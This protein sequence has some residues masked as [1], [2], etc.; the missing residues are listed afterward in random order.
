MLIIKKTFRWLIYA[1]LVV[2]SLMLIVAAVIRFVIFPNIDH[3]KDDISK[4]ISN[5]IGLKTTIGNIQTGWDGLSPEIR[6]SELDI[7]DDTQS[8]LH[9]NNIK[10]TFSWLS[11]PTLH[12]HLSYISIDQPK[13]TIHRK[14]NG[15]IY[16][17]GIAMTGSGEPDFANWILSQAHIR[18]KNAVITWQDDVKQTPPFS[19][20]QVTLNLENPAW[21]KI[22]GQHLFTLS[23]KPS[24]GT[25]YPIHLDGSFFGRNVS[26]LDSWRGTI[27]L[28]SKALDLTAWEPWLN[29]PVD[30]QS[31]LGD[32]IITFLFSNNKIDKIKAD[33][34]LQN[35]TGRIKQDAPLFNVNLLSGILTWEAL[36]DT[37][38]VTAQNIKL[39]TQN[40]HSIEDGSG[41]VSFSKRN[42]KPWL[43]TSL[44]FSTFNLNF[45]KQIEQYIDIPLN[46]SEPLNALSP[47]GELTNLALSFQGN[48]EKPTHFHIKSDFNNLGIDAYEKI[49]G[50][51]NLKG[52]IDA[53]EDKGSIELNTQDATLNLKDILRWPIPAKD[54][55]GKISWSNKGRLK[56]I[57][58]DLI[59]ASDHIR[60]K[61]TASYDMNGIK[62]GYLDIKGEFDDG[63]AKYAPF[64]Y[65][66]IMGKET[67]DWLDSAIVSGKANDVLLTV[68]GYVND[69][70][71]ID[72]QNKPDPNL[73]QFKVSARITDAVL[74]YGKS[75]PKIEGLALNMLFEGNSMELNADK[76]K[77]Y[78]INILK[79]KAVIPMLNTYGANSQELRIDGV[80][81]GPVAE[82]IK[83]INNSPV[84]DVTLGFTDDLKTAGTGKLNLKLNLPLNHIVDSTFEGDYLI[85]NGTIYANERLDF[86][87]ISN[88][89]GLLNFDST[90]IHSKNIK[91]EVLGGPLQFELLTD[92]DKTINIR[93]NGSISDKGI[94]Q[95]AQNLFTQSLEGAANW[96]ADIAIKKPIVN[97]SLRSDLK[98]LSI[99]L[100]APIGKSS[101]QIATL[102]IIK[103]QSLA[104]QDNVEIT[105]KDIIS[106]LILRN[107]KNGELAFDRGDIAFN[108]PPKLPS[109]PSLSIHGRFDY[110]NA[111]EWIALNKGATAK[112]TTSL[113]V[114]TTDI[115]IDKLDIFNRSLNGLNITSTPDSGPLKITLKSQEIDGFIEWL[116]PEK[117]NTNGKVIAHLK[118]LHIPSSNDES[119]KTEDKDIRKLDNKYPALDIQADDFKLGIKEFGLLELKAFQID[120]DWV[121]EQLKMTNADYVFQSEGR[122][123][124]WARNPNTNLE[125]SLAA[126]NVGKTFERLGQPNVIKGGVALISGRL[127]WPGSPHQFKKTGLTGQFTLGASKGEILKVQPGVGRLFGL[128][129]LQSLPRRLTLDFRDLFSEGFA[130]DVISATAKVD[131]GVMQSNDFFMTGP[132][133]ETKIKGQI[134]LNEETQN[135]KVKVVPHIS[136]T[137]SLAALAGGPIAGAAAF[138]AQKLLKDPLNKIAQTE[139]TITGTWANPIDSEAKPEKNKEAPTISPL[140]AQQN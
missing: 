5:K 52:K 83:F 107:E 121:I 61:L 125:F 28:N 4:Q 72:K 91:G 42:K 131:N 38:T 84:K 55:N 80:S 31:G 90:G 14:E 35:L 119:N 73:G 2:L 82:G 120:D 15:D 43:S 101:D 20:S 111:D 6:I 13:L 70:P 135:L 26:K 33:I 97:L 63:N 32:S 93:A 94:Q 126:N 53:D 96:S 133:A 110:L 17:A 81:E 100:P 95:Y 113:K 8:A 12:P 45:L 104:A 128:L 89:N 47:Q 105:Y 77:I 25:Q 16:I 30:L 48:P 57:A 134:D 130:F 44:N 123:Q 23:A 46:L 132:A 18:I 9:L 69:F 27:N 21:R 59:I 29:Y 137:L 37:T 34:T 1:I 22:F 62:G 108:I 88:I 122:W 65:P 71:F 76:G 117:T 109:T 3:Y 115:V 39:N 75:W 36:K 138:I 64:Y 66:T 98:G 124:N 87:E 102:M 127:Q 50:F 92:S 112:N 86:P 11:I 129:T 78:G 116:K 118:K 106:A 139:Y 49:P 60:G 7:Y 79:G 10:G 58:N 99:N 40:E 114:D 24:I 103:K 140:N 136:D 56:V 51:T 19:L 54:L 85:N 68:K 74:E 41:Y 67:V